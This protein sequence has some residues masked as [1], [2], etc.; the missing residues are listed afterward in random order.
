MK[1]NIIYSSKFVWL[2]TARVHYAL[3]NLKST[4]QFEANYFLDKSS[5]KKDVLNKNLDAWQSCNLLGMRRSLEIIIL[6]KQLTSNIHLNTSC[7]II[8]LTT[9]NAYVILK[10]PVLRISFNSISTFRFGFEKMQKNSKYELRLLKHERLQ[11]LLDNRFF[12]N[13]LINTHITIFHISG[14]NFVGDMIW[15]DNWFEWFH[16]M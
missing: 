8:V 9:A 1:F 6:T 5:F 11:H 3:H 16:T 2:Y 10:K 12:A 13:F 14:I 4:Y 7:L 15:V